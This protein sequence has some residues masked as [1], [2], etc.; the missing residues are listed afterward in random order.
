MAQVHGTIFML[1]AAHEHHE[2][3]EPESDITC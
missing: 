2:E 3:C 1:G